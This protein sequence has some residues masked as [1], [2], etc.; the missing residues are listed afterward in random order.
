L[1]RPCGAWYFE[2]EGK[3]KGSTSFITK[4]VIEQWQQQKEMK[5]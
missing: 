5:I 1:T 3:Q 4:E 2:E